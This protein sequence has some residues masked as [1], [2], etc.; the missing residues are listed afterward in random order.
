MNTL[1]VITMADLC[2]AGSYISCVHFKSVGWSVILYKC[3]PLSSGQEILNHR[4]DS[5]GA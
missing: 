5:L 2:L 3:P 1:A 4:T